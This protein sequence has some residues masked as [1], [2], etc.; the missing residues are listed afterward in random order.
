MAPDHG[1][2]GNNWSHTRRE[3]LRTSTMGLD[4]IALGR[5]RE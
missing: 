1:L 3:L 4:T 2:T 5:E